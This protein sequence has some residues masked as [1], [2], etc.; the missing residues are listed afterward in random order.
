MCLYEV[1]C[2]CQCVFVGMASLE[3]GPKIALVQ[4]DPSGNIHILLSRVGS[5]DILQQTPPSL[6]CF[7]RGLVCDFPS[8]IFFPS[9]FSLALHTHNPAGDGPSKESELMRRSRKPAGEEKLSVPLP[10]FTIRQADPVNLGDAAL[11]THFI[12]WTV[13]VLPAK[14][15]NLCLLDIFH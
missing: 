4:S 13:T 10:P 15:E 3:S 2:V 9:S 7:Y 12:G 11:R 14:S 1:V 8:T 5:A 6:G